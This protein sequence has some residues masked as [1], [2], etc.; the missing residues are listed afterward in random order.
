[1]AKETNKV[2][3]SIEEKRHMNVMMYEIL[4]DQ[5]RVSEKKQEEDYYANDESG[6]LYSL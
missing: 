3:M 4:I 1:M 2:K 5:M 6:C